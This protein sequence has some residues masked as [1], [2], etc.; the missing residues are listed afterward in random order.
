M[1]KSTQPPEQK[2][3]KKPK[4]L[5]HGPVFW[6]SVILILILIV[7]TMVLGDTAETWFNDVRVGITDSASWLFVAGVNIFIGFALFFAFGKYG[8]IRLGGEKAKPDF[9][10]MAWFAM[11]FSAGMGIGLM[12]FAVAEPVWHILYPRH[13]EVGTI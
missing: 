3:R 2:K 13:A 5:L 6:P 1:S 10:T 11:L 7:G 4:L 9:S 8:K 12:F